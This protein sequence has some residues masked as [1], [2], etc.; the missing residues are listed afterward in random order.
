MIDA[1]A[2]HDLPMTGQGAT[3]PPH[4]LHALV[5]F[6]NHGLLPFTGR[7][8]QA[9]HII[10]IWRGAIDAPGLG[11]ILLLGEAGMGKSRLIE[12]VAARVLKL[13]GAVVH[14]KLFPESATSIVPLLA[15]A[16]WRFSEARPQLRIE[17]E[18]NLS[19]VLLSLRKLARL[20][21]T[22]LVIEDL[23]LLGGDALGDFSLMLDALADEVGGGGQADRPGSDHDDG[24]PGGGRVHGGS[25]SCFD[26]RQCD[27]PPA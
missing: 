2:P 1:R 8:R 27:V 10:G 22:L 3:A 6:I 13:E 5:D 20:R 12:E 14:A 16:L 4:V 19:S 17:P 9:D 23:H 25:S 7:A 24:Q 18:E 15:R 21:R 11:A 26:I